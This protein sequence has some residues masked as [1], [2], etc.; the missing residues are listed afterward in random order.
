MNKIL[1]A[2]DNSE[3]HKKLKNIKDFEVYEKDIQ[4]REGILDLLKINNKFDI[5][6]IY[7]KL[8]G[9]I[10]IK[11]LIE[12][13][14]NIKNEI[15]IIF[16]LENKNEELEEILLNENIRNIFYNEEIN[17][18]EFINKIKNIN[19]SEE[20]ILKKEID[21]L[22][23]IIFS[24]NNELIK[25]KKLNNINKI[26]IISE[27]KTYEDIKDIL[28]KNLNNKYR[29]T[30]FNI[31]NINNKKMYFEN[32]IYILNNNFYE[33]EK[34]KK[35]I[36]SNKNT[37]INIIFIVNKNQ[38]NIKILK[39]IFKKYVFLGKIKINKNN[40]YLLDKKLIKKIGGL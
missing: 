5:L 22:N 1:T 21:K 14:K 6:I 24:Q 37:N 7:E 27:K 12:K 32:N 30:F 16:I 9:E 10:N 3:F 20:E 11:Q 28:I 29:I 26:T 15:K 39:C 33:I 35:F 2:L 18:K 36:K 38:I 17:F 19:L 8:S 4:Y 31:N 34:F 23:K 13:I 40:K 25:Y